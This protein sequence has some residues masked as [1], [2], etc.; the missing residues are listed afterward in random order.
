MK[1]LLRRIGYSAC[2]TGALLTSAACTVHQD[3]VPNI[4]GPSEFALT[5]HATA[6]PDEVTQ[7][8][9]SQS[10]IRVKAFDANGQAR[11][12][13]TFRLEGDN[14]PLEVFNDMGYGRL[15]ATNTA[16]TGT[17]GVATFVYTAPP[18]VPV[19][20]GGSPSILTFRVVPVGTNYQTARWEKLDVRLVP[21]PF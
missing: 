12:G 10:T 2:V 11:S 6:T 4:A 14:F 9:R 18:G 3:E 13:V 19:S 8:G 5:Y 20:S 21:P 15:E 17:D 7:D 16:S 1:T